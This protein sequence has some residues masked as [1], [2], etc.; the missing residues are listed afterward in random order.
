MYA[1]ITSNRSHFPGLL[2]RLFIRLFICLTLASSSLFIVKAYANGF[3]T[4]LIEGQLQPSLAP[5]IENTAP[6][7][8][9]I[10]TY[11]IQRRYNPLLQSPFFRHFFSFP[12]DADICRIHVGGDFFNQKYYRTGAV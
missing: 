6:A 8:V 4:R 3:P 5:I 10:A 11:T 12:E 1:Q 7:V 2:M 9:N